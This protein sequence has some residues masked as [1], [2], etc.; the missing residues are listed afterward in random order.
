MVGR[1]HKDDIDHFYDYG[2][3]IPTGTIYLGDPAED[4]SEV[5]S[6]MAAQAI[7]SIHLM[8]HVDTHKELTIIM[9]NVGGDE[10]H[11]LGIIDAIA[12]H[13]GYVTIK[14]YGQ[15]MSMGSLILQAADS[16]IMM[17]NSTL[18]IHYGTWEYDGGAKDFDK[19]AEENKR[20]CRWMEDYYLIRIREAKPQFSQN[21]LKKML[22]TDTFLS[23]QQTVEYGLAD[24][25]GDF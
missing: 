19:W 2:I 8:S 6:V 4:E 1:K 16:R 23:A 21:A 18:M 10:Y 5:N 7:K 12:A 13:K 25:V 9:N 20:L 11:G 3:H 14:V 17:P 24:S 15:A 22:N